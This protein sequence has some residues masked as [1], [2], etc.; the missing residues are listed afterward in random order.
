MTSVWL[1]YLTGADIDTLGVTH[2]DIVGAVEDVLVDHGHGRVV[3]EP[4]THLV[5]D[6]GGKGHFNILRGHLSAKQVSGVK[7]VGDFVGNFERGLPSEMALILLFDPETGM[8]RAIVDGTMI[9]EART[10]AMT[11]VGAKYLARKDSRVLGHIGARGTA[12]W[13]VVLLDSL[14]DFA[15][16]RVTSKRP[17][18]REGFG[19]RLS[20]ELG[21]PVRVCESA[22][23][24]L[25]G[26]DIMVEA[27]RLIEPE[28]LVRKDFLR[29]GTF[30]VPYGTIS[31]LELNL[32]DAVD[33]VVVDNWRESQSGNPRFGALRPQLNAGLLTEQRVHAEIGDVVAGKKPGRENDEERI[34]FWHRGLSTTDLAVAHMILARAEAAGAGTML[35]YR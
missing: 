22:E 18:S 5:P 23:E 19:Q 14:F 11:A 35:P 26:A 12:W 29:P 17:E 3:F 33:K 4:R 15:E 28:P 24:T 32:L 16:I 8:P 7:V 10:G 1:R 34:L 30:L 6:N 13:N 9:T 21:K 20:E 2:A 25:D 31:A 27:S